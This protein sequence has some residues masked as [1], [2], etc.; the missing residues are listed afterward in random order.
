MWCKINFEIW[1]A[2]TEKARFPLFFQIDFLRTTAKIF[3]AEVHCYSFE[4]KG[5]LLAL[6]AFYVKG[7]KIIT[8]ESFS[9]TALWFDD[10]LNDLVY[11]ECAD[12]L[13]QLLRANFNKISLRL[14]PKIKDLR[15]FIW[16]N[17]NV[18]NK[19][20]YI[21]KGYS[22][23]HYSVS[24]NIAKLSENYYSFK[25]E[26]VEMTSIMINI[27]FLKAL[28][29]SNVVRGFYKSL[30]IDWEKLG[31]IKAF[32]VYKQTELICS[33]IA[34]LDDN[35]SKIYTI[36]LNNVGLKE[37]YA[38]TFLYQS[39]INW[40]KKNNITE[41]DLCGANLPSV[42]K[43]K[44]YFNAELV[45]YYIVNFN[46]FNNNLA[47]FKIKIH[48]NIKRISRKISIRKRFF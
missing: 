33:N 37:K 48:L 31:F 10:E 38:H 25:V 26:K 46:S 5:K 19:Y 16:S 14:D 13:I 18:E 45:S 2:K 40:G 29:F 12:S 28:G 41:I 32:N 34:I 6:G 43:F 22:E 8:P 15:P 47:I 11:L 9:F 36:L 27:E 17:F 3:N 23:P 20:T 44:S 1:K 21:K 30:I 4:K 35:A 42:S 39:I 7:K 24:K